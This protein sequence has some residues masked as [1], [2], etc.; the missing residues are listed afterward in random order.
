LAPGLKKDSLCVVV[1]WHRTDG[2]LK[3]AS[4]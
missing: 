2:S 4:L 3:G 1:R